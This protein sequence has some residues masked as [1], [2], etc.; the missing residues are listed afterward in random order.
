ML[1]QRFI[2]MI[3]EKEFHR[4]FTR[5]TPNILCYCLLFLTVMCVQ[6]ATKTGFLCIHWAN[7]SE[8]SRLFKNRCGSRIDTPQKFN[9]DTQND[10]PWKRWLL[11]NVAFFWICL[12]A[13][14]NFWG[15]DVF[16]FSSQGLLNSQ[17][18]MTVWILD[19]NYNVT[20]WM[21][22]KDDW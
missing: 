6:D 15:V 14:L 8:V 7:I 9:I 18:H 11:L 4:M 5:R 21:H 13:M 1:H 3:E 10:R 16:C 2:E 20:H 22:K 19:D 12:G 17:R